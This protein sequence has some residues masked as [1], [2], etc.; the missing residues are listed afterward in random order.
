VAKSESSAL[1]GTVPLVA[2]LFRSWA[3]LSLRESPK[4]STGRGPVTC[5]EFLEL[6]SPNSLP[7]NASM[8]SRISLGAIEKF[9]CILVKVGLIL[10]AVKQI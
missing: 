2:S 9:S 6:I 3:R 4:T 1:A 8:Q 10:E 7:I 5:P